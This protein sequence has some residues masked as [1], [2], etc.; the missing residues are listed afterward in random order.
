MLF[1]S[2]LFLFVFPLTIFSISYQDFNK[3]IQGLQP[4]LEQAAEYEKTGQSV[5]FSKNKGAIKALYHSIL[6]SADD[7][8]LTTPCY[9]T[10]DNKLLTMSIEDDEDEFDYKFYNIM[11]NYTEEDDEEDEDLSFNFLYYH[12]EA[13]KY[14]DSF[15]L[16]SIYKKIIYSSVADFFV[17][18]N[19]LQ[20]SRQ[21][22]RSLEQSSYTKIPPHLKNYF[23]TIQE[24]IK[25]RIDS[26]KIIED[27]YLETLEALALMIQFQPGEEN[28]SNT[29]SDDEDEVNKKT[30]SFFLKQYI[31]NKAQ[32]TGTLSISMASS[33]SFLDT[34]LSTDTF[35]ENTSIDI[36]AIP[37]NI[38]LKSIVIDDVAIPVSEIKPNQ[39]KVLALK[40]FPNEYCKNYVKTKYLE[41]EKRCQTEE[42]EARI[43]P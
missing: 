16:L 36:N 38:H 1:K 30:K 40:Y 12:E 18:S 22:L 4:L 15:R 35:Y 5:K 43:K 41:T 11:C 39:E 32:Y 20:Q 33:M 19:T 23:D 8:S 9:F 27:H 28:D 13:K 42:E 3:K 24:F 25:A 2:L 21:E 31:I 6:S 29:E 7:I 14:L 17:D 37:T 26:I 10:F 34:W